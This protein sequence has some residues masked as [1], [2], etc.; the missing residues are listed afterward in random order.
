[1]RK[2][3]IVGLVATLALGLAAPAE[4]QLVHRNSQ[5][6]LLFNPLL[7][8]TDYQVR[9]QIAAAGYGNIKLN[10]PIESQ[11]QVKATRGGHTWLID[12]NRCLNRI[13]SVTGLN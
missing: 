9:Q 13:D 11:I 2:L 1:M 10:A 12:F 8:L 3:F 4:A 5:G 6:Q 7:C